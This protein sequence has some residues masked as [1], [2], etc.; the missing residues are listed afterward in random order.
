MKSADVGGV[1]GVELRTLDE[2]VLDL[3]FQVLGLLKAH[4]HLSL[5]H[6]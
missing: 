2:E 3:M 6:I 1:R 4:F 5:I